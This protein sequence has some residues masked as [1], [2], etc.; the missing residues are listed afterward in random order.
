MVDARQRTVVDNLAAEFRGRGLSVVQFE[1]CISHVDDVW[2]GVW[3]L[4]KKKNTFVLRVGFGPVV[5]EF[6]KP[7]DADVVKM[8][9]WVL[10]WLKVHRE[11]SIARSATPME[12]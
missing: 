6:P 4:P 9:D 7:F 1:T 12:D 2:V 10:D 8:A 5:E 11:A 3:V